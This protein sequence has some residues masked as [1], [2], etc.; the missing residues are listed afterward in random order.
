MGEEGD[1]VGFVAGRGVVLQSSGRPCTSSLLYLV[2]ACS[3]GYLNISLF[4]LLSVWTIRIFGGI[5]S[6]CSETIPAFIK[7]AAE[8][9]AADLRALFRWED[10]SG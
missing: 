3:A 10:G 1:L 9:S 4:S 6:K 8:L 7:A 2:R 5:T